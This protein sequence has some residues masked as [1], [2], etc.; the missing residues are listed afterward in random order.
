MTVI[1]RYGRSDDSPI[2]ISD[3]SVSTHHLSLEFID[4]SWF[5]ED[6]NSTN[7]TFVN[8]KKVS[9]LQ[10]V[11]GDVIHLGT[12]KTQFENGQLI[13]PSVAISS[14]QGEPKEIVNPQTNPRLNRRV[15]LGVCASLVTLTVVLVAL[16]RILSE[17]P[18]IIDASKATVFIEVSNSQDEKCWI[19]SGFLVGDGS[20]VATNAHVA[21]ASSDASF[22]EKDC[23]RIRIGYT[24]NSQEAP[25]MFRQAEV[26]E[27]SEVNDLALL[28][29]SDPLKNLGGLPLSDG[30]AAIGAPLTVF[31]YPGL[32]GATITVNNGVVSGFDNSDGDEY[33]KISAVINS[34]NSGGPVVGNDGKVLGVASAANLAGVECSDNGD[35]FTDG[36]NVGLARPTKLISQWLAQRSN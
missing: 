10:I 3:P 27:I 36:Q 34:G 22:A 13:V 24:T 32:G 23:T 4:G 35:C 6:L 31:G 25:S 16:N 11:N 12:F 17:S 21:A 15:F 20:M 29:I 33:I 5:V 19:G 9:R 26:I 1:A 30:P 14:V 2:R 18:T 28:Q 8:G 7:G